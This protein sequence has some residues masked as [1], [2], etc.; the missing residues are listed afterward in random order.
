MNDDTRIAAPVETPSQGYAPSPRPRFDQ[1]THVTR[2][3]V[4]RHIWGDPEAGNVA[5]WIYA[6]TD[7]IHTLVF[8]VAPSGRFT[9]SESFR[10]IFGA[11]EVLVVLRG[12]MVIANPETAEVHLLE[13]GEAVGFGPDTWHHVFA[14]GPG[15]LR[16]IEFFAPPPATGT[17]GPYARTK[18]Y[19]DHSS[20]ED[21]S[22]IGHWPGAARSRT[23]LHPIR[24]TDQSYRLSGDALIGVM[25]STD[26]L[27]VATLSLSPGAASA[28]QRRGGD[29][30]I[31]GTEGFTHVS[32]RYAGEAY[33][34]EM[35]PGDACYLPVG[36]THE[37]RN[38][39]ADTSTALIGVA[40]AWLSG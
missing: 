12:R 8:G 27:T 34:F 31:Y 38:F 37:Y 4:T 16:V 28:P 13:A 35:G 40:P 25:A 23:T 6:S 15:D 18:P 29:E 39:T 24:R 36:T 2:R 21:N 26:Q 11:D 10:T 5:D 14:H 7:R 1:P 30:V 22:V 3:D 20:Y 19:L 9:H 17:S 33:V 32:A